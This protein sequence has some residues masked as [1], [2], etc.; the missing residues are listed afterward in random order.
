LICYSLAELYV[1]KSRRSSPAPVRALRP[2]PG[3]PHA[4]RGRLRTVGLYL[5]GR[6]GS[7]G[8]QELGHCLP[9]TRR[10]ASR[11]F[12]RWKIPSVPFVETSVQSQTWSN[13]VIKYTHRLGNTEPESQ[14]IGDE[15]GRQGVFNHSV[16]FTA[17]KI[18]KASVKQSQGWDDYVLHG[19]NIWS[20]RK[21][22]VRIVWC[23]GVRRHA[24]RCWSRWTML[25][26]N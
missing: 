6:G 10:H 21:R 2:D 24:S 18:P 7:Q 5:R 25:S 15:T 1:V 20:I 19:T 12:S 16:G 23:R 3:Q 11:S 17:G 9:R 13:K 22:I 4:H 14:L 26:E 8:P